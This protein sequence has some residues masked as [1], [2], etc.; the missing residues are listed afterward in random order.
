MTLAPVEDHLDTE[1]IRSRANGRTAAGKRQDLRRR[2]HRKGE[3]FE[4][5]GQHMIGREDVVS[6]T[7]D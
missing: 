3:S 1:G 5:G 4:K 6:G 2:N 7:A